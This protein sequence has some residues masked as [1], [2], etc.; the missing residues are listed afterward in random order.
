MTS[1]D[2]R[3]RWNSPPGW[4]PP[5]A[6]WVPPPGW[7]PDA[8]W[9][10]PPPGWSF[11]SPIEVQAL[12]ASVTTAPAHSSGDERPSWR[13]RHQDKK[14][15]AAQ[16]ARAEQLEQQR[17]LLRGE[18]RLVETFSPFPLATVGVVAKRDE[19]GVA[20]IQGAGLIQVVRQQGHYTAGYGGVS[21][22][23]G[24]GVRLHAGR[25]RGHY[26][27]GPDTEQQVDTGVVHLTSARVLFVGAKFTREWLFDK[28]VGRQMYGNNHLGW[29][30]LA[31]SNRQK[32]SGFTFPPGIRVKI[33][34]LLDMALALHTGGFEKLKD[35]LRSDLQAL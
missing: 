32:T 34:L 4:P 26:V 22:N 5:P 6:G 20:T 13:E 35:D 16:S 17:K 25:T 29:V 10:A 3:Y 21:Y 19:V 7:T 9:P 1:P 23:L 33:D 14:E 31:V 24:G 12:T 11:W 18:L 28:L 27:P 15:R 2:G 8:G 30:D